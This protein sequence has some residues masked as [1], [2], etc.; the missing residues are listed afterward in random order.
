[1]IESF[2]SSWELFRATYLAGWLVAAVM[3]LLGVVIVLRRQ[4]FLGAALSQTAT[5]GVAAALGGATALGVPA[6]GEHATWLAGL[7]AIAAPVLAS[8]PL[9]ARRDRGANDD[10]R[11]ALVFVGAAAAAVLL[12]AHSPHGLEEVQ[13]LLSS[14]ILGATEA[15][16]GWLLLGTVLLATFLARHRDAVL[17]LSV[18]RE[19]AHALGMPVRRWELGLAVVTGLALGSVMRLGGFVYSFGCLVLPV[20][21]ARPLVRRMS[22][23]LWLAPVLAVGAAV[24]GFV[25]ANHWDFPP[26]Q[27]TVAL[28]AGLALGSDLLLRRR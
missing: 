24:T 2:L 8:L 6:R 23:L 12:V 21:I 3:G 22:S 15:D 9:M 19:T 25:L 5:L 1:M 13:R 11:T 26:A 4:V 27:L 17:L 10:T 7:A 14:S 28:L 18:D 20:L 16:V